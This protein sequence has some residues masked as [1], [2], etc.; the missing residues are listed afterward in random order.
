M[1]RRICTIVI[2]P[3][4][5]LT[6]LNELREALSQRHYPKYIIN[7]G[8]EKAS[9]LDIDTLRT[10]KHKVSN[11]NIITLV[12]TYIPQQTNVFNVFH[13]NKNKMLFE[14][15]HLKKKFQDTKFINSRRQAPSLK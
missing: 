9:K 15:N 1:A 3:E 2:D 5:R 7:K 13:E 11:E 6:R 8:I 12:S 10:P 4:L 14:D